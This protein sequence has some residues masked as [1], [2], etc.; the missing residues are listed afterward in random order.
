[1]ISSELNHYQ[2]HFRRGPASLVLDF[3]SNVW[4]GI[5]WAGLL[6]LYCSLGSAFPVVRQLPWL[7]M[8]EFEW[9]HWWPFNVL[10]LHFCLTLI[11]VTVR[12]IPLRWVN[13]GVWTI[14]T[15]ILVLCAGSYYYFTTKVE[16][17]AP[18][19]RRQIRI[20][21]P[22][23]PHVVT[24]PALPGNEAAV[25][26]G[27]RGWKFRIQDTNA[28]WPILSDEHKG[29]KAFAVNVM[30]TPPAGEPFIRQ[31]LAG[32]PQYTE[33]IL[34]GK[35]RAIKNLDRK[36]VDEALRL[37]L[38]YEPTKYFHVMDTW[39]LF[40]RGE[41]ETEWK[42]RPIH[43]M[44]RYHHYVGSR[45]QVFHEPNEPLPLRA[46][47]LPVEPGSGEDALSG[48]PVRVTGY[49]RY[50][51]LEKRW[52]EGGDRLFPVLGLSVL[53]EPSP[54]QSHELVAFDSQR[55]H[56]ADGN[57]EFI[58]LSERAQADALPEDSRARLTV[59][60]PD[61]N[62]NLDLP[63]TQDLINA[64]PR[65]IEGT[66]FS[67]RL[68]NLHDRLVLADQDRPVSIAVVEIQSPEKS[69]RRWVS[70]QPER[71]R[72]LPVDGDPHGGGFQPPDSRLHM[73][74]QPQT[75]PLIFAAYPG[76]LHFVFNGPN[77]RAITKDLKVGETVQV[78]P[79]LA[80]RVDSLFTNAVA[81]VKPYIVPRE[82]QQPK[83]GEHFAMIRLEVGRAGES[84]TEWLAFQPYVFPSEDYAYSGR[85]SFAPERIRLPGGRR[86]EVAFSRQRRE[87]PAPIALEDFALDTHVGGYT[88]S[89]STIRNYVSQLRFQDGGRWTDPRPI[90][91][92]NPTEFGGYW[93]FQST[94]DKPPQENPAGGLNFTGLGVGNRNGVYVQLAGC[95]LS[96]AGM[97]FAFYVKPMI[98]R[99]RAEQSRSRIGRSS[100]PEIGI[101]ESAS[102]EVSSAT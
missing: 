46:L 62:V 88:G 101:Q 75:S 29:E 24:L 53:S 50:A 102:L 57:V 14:H 33:D 94:W 49:L 93:Y 18:V 58:W 31:L 6:F 54:P 11:V 72:D 38:D 73:T 36:L 39:A 99:R 67:F 7:E 95:C 86:V 13:A 30:V 15:G 22:G 28:E 43:G 41:G 52:R 56:A 61:T 26:A 63:I 23:V 12:R 37:S 64:P 71:T 20:E 1:M 80:L 51:H 47:D 91:V 79:R 74:Y 9:F 55:N 5:F 44:P 96:V 8:T 97:I 90:S 65:P 83:A 35:G 10:I 69:F 3:F 81:Q 70:D 92:N 100:W 19:F 32:F 48:T 85:F 87:L 59:S 4:L 77:G 40:I 2:P 27:D 34:P 89:V 76:G 42:E 21:V 16:G 82:R 25:P 45:D 17:D 60:V 68:L 66:P 84:Q 98:R 78:V